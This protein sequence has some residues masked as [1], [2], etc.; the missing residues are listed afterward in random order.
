M[1]LRPLT[2]ITI[3]LGL[4]WPALSH[5]SQIQLSPEPAQ[6]A[7]AVSATVVTWGASGSSTTSA[8]TA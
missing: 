8:S 4:M 6:R 7:L 3:I 2:S 5:A 1:R